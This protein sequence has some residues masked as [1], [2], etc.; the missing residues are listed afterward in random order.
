MQA[1]IVYKIFHQNKPENRKLVV[2]IGIH[3]MIRK[4]LHSEYLMFLVQKE[5]H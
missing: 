1:E 2:F 5:F 3:A 4:S